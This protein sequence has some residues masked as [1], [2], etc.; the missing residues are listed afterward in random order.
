MTTLPHAVRFTHAV[1]HYADA[2][3]AVD[4]FIHA[5]DAGRAA[6]LVLDG[7]ELLVSEERVDAD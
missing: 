5:H 1:A 7:E 2:D 6:T 3:D 4:A